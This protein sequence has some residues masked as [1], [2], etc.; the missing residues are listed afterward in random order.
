MIWVLLGLLIIYAIATLGLA[1]FWLKIPIF[2]QKKAIESP[3][4]AL[5]VVVVVRN[6]AH[7]IDSLLRDLRNQ[8]YQRFEV[9][10]VDDHSTDGTATKIAQFIAQYR[11]VAWR[12]LALQLDDLVLAHKKAAITLA[13]SQAKGTFIITTDGDCNVSPQWLETI[14]AYINSQNQRVRFISAPVLMRG[15]TWFAKMQ[16]IEFSSLILA[17]AAAI[18]AQK[19]NM[20]SAANM[21]FCKETFVTI[22]GYKGFEHIASGDDE[23]LLH[24]I[25]KKYP[26]SIRYLKAYNAVVRTH[27]CHSVW[28][29]FNQRIRWGS[30]WQHY[31]NIPAQITAIVVFGFQF[32]SVLVLFLG[33]TNQI[34]W[35]S[36]GLILLPKIISEWI[37]LS[38]GLLF[39]KQVRLIPLIPLVQVFHSPYIV[40][41]GVVAFFKKTKW[42]GR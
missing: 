17:G 8:T 42:K 34:S 25:A 26:D 10:V 30:K 29:F 18:E 2:D 13:V 32:V 15:E 1:F 23:F 24:K 28:A 41:V 40:V 37:F 7:N 6:E 22:D 5:T 4:V 33:I 36:V 3:T 27:A 39:F 9:I 20:C 11:L 21:I 16:T 14:A 31:D 12:L 38:L 35:L 19:P